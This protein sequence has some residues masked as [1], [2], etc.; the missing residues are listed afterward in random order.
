MPRSHI[1]GSSCRIHYG[2]KLTD[3]PGKDYIRGPLRMHHGLTTGF[4]GSTKDN[5][6]NGLVDNGE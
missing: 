6:E 4:D 5:A 1:H 3:D 2:W